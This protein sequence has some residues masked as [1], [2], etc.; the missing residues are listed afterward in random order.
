M[1]KDCY[2]TIIAA[3]LLTS[4]ALA[5]TVQQPPRLMTIMGVG[6]S[7]CSSFLDVVEKERALLPL[8]S[9]PDTIATIFYA[10]YMG[11]VDGFITSYSDQQ[12]ATTFVGMSTTMRARS[13][14]VENYCREHPTDRF[15][16]AVEQLTMML[17]EKDKHPLDH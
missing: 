17:Q 12:P 8:N 5:Q 16:R 1:W 11:W 14:W 13:R 15:V 3:L 9:Q 10:R 6:D 7:D 2:I 4:P